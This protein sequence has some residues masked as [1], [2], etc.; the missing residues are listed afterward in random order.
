VRTNDRRRTEDSEI[1]CGRR[2]ETA[3]LVDPEGGD[4]MNTAAVVITLIVVIIAA[5][6][7][8]VLRERRDRVTAERLDDA[9]P[10]AGLRAHAD[11]ERQAAGTR[12]EA[13]GMSWSAGGENS[14]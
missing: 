7:V 2:G 8:L 13:G 9:D 12:G 14:A 1:C 3:V 5:T 6:I 11:A 10:G 4:I